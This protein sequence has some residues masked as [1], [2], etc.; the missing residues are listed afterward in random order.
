MRWGLHPVCV[1]PNAGG[2]YCPPGDIRQGSP[3]REKPV[4][5]GRLPF[6]VFRSRDLSPALRLV[7]ES[8][9]QG[10]GLVTGKLRT[11]AVLEQRA[12]H[13]MGSPGGCLQ[14]DS[15]GPRR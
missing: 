15:R 10:K 7:E 1:D 11:V 9:A 2:P 5:R 13:G 12:F 3:F 6:A 4:V 14:V 8:V